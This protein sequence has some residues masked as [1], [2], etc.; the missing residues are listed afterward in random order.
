MLGE[1]ALGRR[2]RGDG[3]L[4]MMG[5]GEGEREREEPKRVWRDGEGRWKYFL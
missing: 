3:R 5:E 4:M 2:I 1:D